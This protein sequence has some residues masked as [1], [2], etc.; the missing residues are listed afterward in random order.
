MDEKI[1]PDTNLEIDSLEV[2]P[3]SD[4]DLEDVAGGLDSCTSCGS[5]SFCSDP[6]PAAALEG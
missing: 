2:E 4:Q 1:Q 3:L 6:E 5:F